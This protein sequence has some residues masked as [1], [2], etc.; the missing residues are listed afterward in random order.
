MLQSFIAGLLLAGVSAI[1]FVAFKHPNGYARLFPYMILAATALLVG[2]TVW[3]IAIEA[4]WADLTNFLDN[5]FHQEALAAKN[6]LSP[7]Y[8]WIGIA[9]I[10]VVLFLLVNLKLPPF[11][12][13]TDSDSSA[14]ENGV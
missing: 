6:R 3:H 12:R 13:R 9:Y 8:V 2:I 7:P 5:E 4:M 10:G 11:L 1:S 14:R